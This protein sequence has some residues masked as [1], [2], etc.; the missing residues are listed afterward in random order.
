MGKLNGWQRLWVVFTLL[1]GLLTG[2]ILTGD[3]PTQERI[4]QQWS[5]AGV[6]EVQEDHKTLTGEYATHDQIRNGR[7]DIEI[8]N[9][10]K[11]GPAK[12][13]TE[14]DQATKVFREALLKI[15]AEYESELAKLPSEQFSL[16]IRYLGGWLAASL[17]LYIFGWLLAWVRKG[18]RK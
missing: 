13:L 17:S 1:L 4:Y 11:E 2:G 10:L 12:L 6:R 3:Y 18:F 15:N 9:A 16:V 8:V 7:S 14:N 5:F